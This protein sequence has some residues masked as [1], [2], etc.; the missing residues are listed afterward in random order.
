M[1][2]RIATCVGV[3]A[4]FAAFATAPM[5]VA[6]QSAQTMYIIVPLNTL[7]GLN[8]A[9]IG[10]NDRGWITGSANQQGD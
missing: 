1:K 6:S 2:F 3:I 7:G 4:A 5:R 8:G 9:G 10:I